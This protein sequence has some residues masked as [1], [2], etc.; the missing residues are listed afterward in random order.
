M[1][2]KDDLENLFKKPPFSESDNISKW[3]SAMTSYGPQ[4]SPTS[5]AAAGAAS[6]FTGD[7]S[8]FSQAGQAAGK[9]ETAFANWAT[10]MAGGMVF[11]TTAAVPPSGPVGFAD[12]FS[13]TYADPSDIAGTIAGKIDDWVKTGVGPDGTPANWSPP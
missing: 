2:L 9:L 8:G 10:K 6:G 5:T 1:S 12:V 4:V 13:K 11:T 7:L 3:Q